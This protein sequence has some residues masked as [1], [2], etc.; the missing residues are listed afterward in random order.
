MIRTA[1]VQ[2]EDAHIK[3]L[4]G[5]SKHARKMP[6]AGAPTSSRADPTHPISNSPAADAWSRSC[7]PRID[8]D[9]T[10]AWPGDV[11]HHLIDVMQLK[12]DYKMFVGQLLK[13][14]PCRWR[15]INLVFKHDLDAKQSRQMHPLVSYLQVRSSVTSTTAMSAV[16]SPVSP[17]PDSVNPVAD[18]DP[19]AACRPFT[20]VGAVSCSPYQIY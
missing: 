3:W 9:F 12:E 19:C 15:E 1:D 10:K 8:A 17:G 20:K 13:D 18:H 14:R 4:S 11:N 2:A 7:L 6:T 5:T 16:S